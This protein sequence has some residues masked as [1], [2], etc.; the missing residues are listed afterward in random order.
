MGR[1]GRKEVRGGD[2]VIKG[3]SREQICNTRC[4]LDETVINNSDGAKIYGTRKGGKGCDWD[5]KMLEIE[6][7]SRRCVI[8]VML[9][10]IAWE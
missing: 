8:C 6:S 10:N 1:K 9:G 7:R 3:R 2:V 4:T 5:A